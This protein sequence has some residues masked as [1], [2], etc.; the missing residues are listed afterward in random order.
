MEFTT[1]GL[2]IVCTDSSVYVYNSMDQIIH[3]MDCEYEESSDYDPVTN[4]L[5]HYR[6][7]S[8]NGLMEK[9]FDLSLKDITED[10][11]KKR[12]PKFIRA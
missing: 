2:R 7:V 11:F 5:I 8:N 10:E 9:W 6:S 12:N 4:R 3:Y 1:M